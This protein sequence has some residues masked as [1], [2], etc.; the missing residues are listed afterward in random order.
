MA[1]SLNINFDNYIVP[2]GF[3]SIY[4]AMFQ[5]KPFSLF[6]TYGKRPKRLLIC[7]PCL[8]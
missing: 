4:A 6:K 3:M 2:F 5:M 1:V 8:V 7:S